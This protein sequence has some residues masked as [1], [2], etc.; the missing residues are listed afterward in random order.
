MRWVSGLLRQVLYRALLGLLLVHRAHRQPGDLLQPPQG[1]CHPCNLANF[2][3]VYEAMSAAARHSDTQGP[4]AAS[5]SSSSSSSGELPPLTVL[6]DAVAH[7]P[8]ECL[9]LARSSRP[10]FQ[11]PEPTVPVSFTPHGTEHLGLL[12]Q[13]RAQWGGGRDILL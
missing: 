7:L 10:A 5:S 13:V 6:Y 12:V 3:I 8:P 11:P 1:S 4:E 9:V 2:H